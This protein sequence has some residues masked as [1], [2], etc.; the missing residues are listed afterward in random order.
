MDVEAVI[1]LISLAFS[2]FFSAVEIAFISANRLHLA[3]QK[4]KGGYIAG[5]VSH[6]VNNPGY[7]ISTTL[8]G[9]TVALV[10]YGIFMAEL[11]EPS[12]ELYLNQHFSALSEGSL[13]VLV[14]IVQTILSTIIV[15][16]TAEFLPKSISLVNPDALLRA[17]AIP[18]NIIYTIFFPF[19]W[20][21]VHLSKLL[22]TKLFKLEYSEMRPAFG[23]VDLNNYI[24]NTSVPSTEQEP[25]INKEIFS[26]AL[27]FKMMKV[28]DCMVPRKEILAVDV[29][30]DIS[31]LK[32][33]LIESGHSKVLVYED[34]IDNIIGYVHALALFKKPENIREAIKD[35]AVVPETMPA[36]ELMVR[37]ISEHRSLAIIVD[38]YGGTSGLVTIEDIMEEIFGEIEDEFDEDELELTQLDAHTYRLSA[39]HEIEYLNEQ[40]SFAIPEG[41]Y[42]T[43]GGFIIFVN[44]NDIPEEGDLIETDRFIIQVESM[45]DAR[46]DIVKLT[47]LASEVAEGAV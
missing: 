35:I 47:V 21:I 46:I 36:N 41:D 44:R 14:L 8:I 7:F 13:G 2:A 11:L 19:S 3:I 18:M 33:K 10:V 39:R 27:E 32:E 34:S 40:Y 22:I 23:L 37:F 29:E 45:I 25:K 16:V 1:I 12:I 31:E 15:L 6:F 24:H 28:R 43:L 30:D 38:E 26:N 9:N 5:I 20:V 42:D 4:K 17:A